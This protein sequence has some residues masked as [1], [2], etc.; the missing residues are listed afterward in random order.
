MRLIAYVVQ[1]LFPLVFMFGAVYFGYWCYR[2]ARHTWSA[3]TGRP[4]AARPH[5][6]SSGER[7]LLHAAG[8][9]AST[10]TVVVGILLALIVVA[11][12]QSSF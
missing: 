3:L 1:S 5:V 11:V 2:G 12:S 10:V 6:L 4:V 9:I 7:K 8:A